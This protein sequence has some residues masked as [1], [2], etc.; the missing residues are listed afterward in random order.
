MKNYTFRD[1]VKKEDADSIREIVKSSGFFYDDEVDVAVEL[2]D[3]RLTKGIESEY[4][5]IFAD[6]NEKTVGYA[7][8]GPIPCTKASFDL[9]W[10][11]V[12]EN[13]RGSGLGKLI[14]EE[15]VKSIRNMGGKN[16]YIET[17]SREKYI[18][19]QKFYEKTGCILEGRFRNFYDEGDDKLVYVIHC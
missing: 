3:E 2:V 10:I 19:T 17:S 8:F 4:Y 12:H 13:Q 14:L 1:S 15:S 11:A 18:P 6:L 9:Y 7:C 16:I 5:F